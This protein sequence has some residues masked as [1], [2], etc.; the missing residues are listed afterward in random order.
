MLVYSMIINFTSKLDM[1]VWI[2]SEQQSWK[3]RLNDGCTGL[4][5]QLGLSDNR[6]VYSTLVVNYCLRLESQFPT[7]LDAKDIYL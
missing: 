4:A 6:V 3:Y 5:N 2:H 7:D 1:S